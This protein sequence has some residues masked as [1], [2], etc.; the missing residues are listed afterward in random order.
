M[1]KTFRKNLLKQIGI[2]FIILAVLFAGLFFIKN[3]IKESVAQIM[4]TRQELANRTATLN[5]LST[6]RSQHNDFGQAYLN[7]LA[8]IVPQKD[9]LINVSE[10]FGSIARNQDLG[11]GFSFVN[12]VTP[13]EDSGLGHIQ[14][15]LNV[16]GD[17]M[18]QIE[19]FIKNLESFK[20][21]TTVDSVNINRNN[22]EEIIELTLNGKVYFQ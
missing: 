6:L 20:Y 18:D 8:N 15:R 1:N 16:T 21:L 9:Q 11:F 4:S 10:S 19:E 2:A 3:H 22:D 7:V 12:E 5:A 14:F 13:E 17:T